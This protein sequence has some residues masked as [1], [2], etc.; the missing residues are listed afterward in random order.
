ME[1][2]M[3]VY[4]PAVIVANLVGGGVI[5]SLILASVVSIPAYLNGSA[6]LPMVAGLIDQGMAPGAGMAFL[7]AGGPAFLRR[8]QLGSLLVLRFL[9][10]TWD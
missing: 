8:S 7:L 5:G 1:S 10:P 3:L 9:K 6:A 2:L 4:L